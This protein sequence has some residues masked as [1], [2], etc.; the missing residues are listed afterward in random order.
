MSQQEAVERFYYDGNGKYHLDTG[1]Q[2]VPMDQR[3]VIRHLKLW[4]FVDTQPRDGTPGVEVI[5]PMLCEIQTRRYVRKADEINRFG[6]DDLLKRAYELAFD[7]DAEPPPEEL[8]MMLG[9]YPIAA[10]GNLT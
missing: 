6:P 2:L 10:R 1:L 3:S 7:P 9:E 5:N 4:G 8:C